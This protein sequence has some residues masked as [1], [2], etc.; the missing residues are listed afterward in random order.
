MESNEVIIPSRE[1]RRRFGDVSDITIHRWIA[2]GVL[3]PPVKVNGRNYWPEKQ[4]E[5]IQRGRAV[6]A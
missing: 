5:E 3:P 4:I 6:K 1:V 2:R